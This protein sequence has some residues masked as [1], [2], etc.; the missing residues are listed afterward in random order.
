[1]KADVSKV[2]DVARVLEEIKLSGA[3]LRGIVHAAGVLSDGILLQ[4]QWDRFVQVM[5]PKVLGGW[6][7]H[8]LTLD[9]PLEFFVCFSSLA[10]L[11]G[12]PG[13]G[14][15]AAANAFLD[16]LAHQRRAQGLPGLSINWGPWGESGMAASLGNRHRARLAGM[17]VEAIAPVQGMQMLGHVLKL[18]KS[19]VCVLAIN[20]SVFAQQAGIRSPLL[21]ELVSETSAR[22][23]GER[24]ATQ[25]PEL[26]QRL[27]EAVPSERHN[28]LT[29]Y[30]QGEVAAVL[31]LAPSQLPDPREGFFEMGMDSLMAVE[32]KNRLEKSL[33]LSLSITSM[34][35]YSTIEALGNY[36]YR[37][38]LSF[39]TSDQSESLPSESEKEVATS[40]KDIEG[41]SERDVATL[42][43]EELEASRK[44]FGDG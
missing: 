39:E 25:Q 6:N 35:N 24:A 13:Q 28:L 1:V 27:R 8:T 37:D 20:W 2:E 10:S 43:S 22:A 14:N 29:I 33:G 40:L 19:E 5:A 31:G 34:F 11:L 4:Q 26:P 9:T 15:Y 3:P 17:G 16:A 7:L 32:L 42:I 12:A 23:S 41:L 30:L 18:A 21:S 36:L 38:V 44:D